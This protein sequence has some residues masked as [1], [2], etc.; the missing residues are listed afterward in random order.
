MIHGDPEPAPSWLVEPAYIETSR[1]FARFCARG[2]KARFPE[3]FESTL[4]SAIAAD[5]LTVELWT[6]RGLI[7]YYMFFVM[8]RADRVVAI[9]GV[10]ARPDET[11]MLQVR[12]GL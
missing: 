11:W 8:S 4:E 1:R 9:A 3:L 2:P 7:S 10:T 12:R 6:T 5:Y